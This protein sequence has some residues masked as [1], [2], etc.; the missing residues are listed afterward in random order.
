MPAESPV[1]PSKGERGVVFYDAECALCRRGIA[2]WGACLTRR[3]S[4]WQPLQTQGTA[5]GLGVS[6][7]AL[8]EEMALALANGTVVSGVDAWAVL[9]RPVWW[10]RPLGVWMGLPGIRRLGR[11]CYRWVARHRHCLGGRC[12]HAGTAAKR[13]RT[14][15]FLDLP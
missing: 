14:I 12:V 10:L 13:R 3:G 15:P 7:V 2:R 6:E 8:R 4:R 9:M 1:N 5:D 11:L